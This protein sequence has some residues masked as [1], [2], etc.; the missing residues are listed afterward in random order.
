MKSRSWVRIPACA[1]FFAP[2]ENHVIHTRRVPTPGIEPGT[3][4]ISCQHCTTTLSELT[5]N[6][7]RFGCNKFLQHCELF[8]YDLACIAFA[9][10]IPAILFSLNSAAI[11]P[12]TPAL[13]HISTLPHLSHLQ[14][15]KSCTCSSSQRQECS[16]ILPSLKPQDKPTYS[17]ELLEMCIS[18]CQSTWAMKPGILRGGAGGHRRPQAFGPRPHLSKCQANKDHVD[19]TPCYC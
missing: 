16:L 3:C 5:I 13:P 11:P 12:T 19:R 10:I 8:A 6:S 18:S 15:T 9:I 17:H 2:A 7:G 14:A 1:S 4:D